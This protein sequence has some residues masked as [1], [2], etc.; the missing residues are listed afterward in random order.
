MMDLTA[1]GNVGW[2]LLGWLEGFLVVF[3]FCV[4]VAGIALK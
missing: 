3:F 1:T 4:G 2:G